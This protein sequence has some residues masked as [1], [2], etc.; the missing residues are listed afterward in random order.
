M[1]SSNQT[2]VGY[3]P[4][5]GLAGGVRLLLDYCGV[6]Y[7]NKC[8]TDGNEWFEQD[9]PLHAVKND[10]PNL[11]YLVDGDNI[12]TES[13]AILHYIP[14][15][16]GKR[17][18]IGDTDEKFIKVQTAFFAVSDLWQAAVRPCWTKGDYETE[19]EASFKSG[20]I[21][22]K[23]THFNSLLENREFVTGFISIAD[24][25]L[26]EAVELLHDMDA[27][28]LEAYP[29]VVAF[30]KRFL[31]LPQVKAHRQSDKFISLWF[32]KG[33]ATWTNA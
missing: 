4:I 17:E 8:Y 27:A 32:T 21:K 29:N 6:P 30:Y 10:F 15:K 31:E 9:K 23:L 24:F 26:F 12:I 11:P 14:I 5:R 16:A 7:T 22:D 20:D 2:T 28:K 13:S 25:K 19:K 3:W 18:L 1:E 33:M